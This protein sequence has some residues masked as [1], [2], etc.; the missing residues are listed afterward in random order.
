MDMKSMSCL[1]V[2]IEVYIIVS[3]NSLLMQKVKSVQSIREKNADAMSTP[4]DYSLT[5]HA[6]KSC[7]HSS[8]RHQPF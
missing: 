6:W 4:N 5:K 1:T 8:I 2:V 3:G 7:V